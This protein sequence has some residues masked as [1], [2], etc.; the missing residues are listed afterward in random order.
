MAV[1]KEKT[2]TL[3][4]AQKTLDNI[5]TNQRAIIPMILSTAGDPHALVKSWGTGSM[6]WEDAFGIKD[7]QSACEKTGVLR[8]QG[9]RFYIL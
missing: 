3:S 6:H 9:K 2:T 5:Q 1:V 4:V 7:M 8:I